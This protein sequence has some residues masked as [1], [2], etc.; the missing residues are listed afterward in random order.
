M[1]K[2]VVREGYKLIDNMDENKIKEIKSLKRF[3]S[4]KEFTSGIAIGI[5]TGLISGY[6]LL[7]I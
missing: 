7:F 4:T 6:I 1:Y 2:G 5:F 3:I